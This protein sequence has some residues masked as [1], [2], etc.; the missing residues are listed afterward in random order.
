MSSR[1]LS[2]VFLKNLLR[3]KS[4]D[5]GLGENGEK[6]I[7][8]GI[9]EAGSLSVSFLGNEVANELWVSDAVRVHELSLRQKER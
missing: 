4:L 8:G 3:T 1:L 7:P 2:N 5:A 9:T 6:G